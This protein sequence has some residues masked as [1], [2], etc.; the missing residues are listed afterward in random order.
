MLQYQFFFFFYMYD[1]FKNIVN[2]ILLTP[3]WLK[4]KINIKWLKKNPS[5]NDQVSPRATSYVVNSINVHS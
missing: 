2:S 3:I 5:K 1:L 4:K